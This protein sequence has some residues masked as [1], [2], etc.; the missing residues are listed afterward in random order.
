[1]SSLKSVFQEND[2]PKFVKSIKWP[3]RKCHGTLILY[4]YIFKLMMKI[5]LIGIM[6]ILL[7]RRQHLLAWT[8]TE[9][10]LTFTILIHLCISYCR[11]K[12]FLR[13]TVRDESGHWHLWTYGLG[14]QDEMSKFI[15]NHKLFNEVVKDN[16]C[17]TTSVVSI[18]K[19]V[20][21]VIANEEAYILKDS[22]MKRII[23]NEKVNYEVSI[24]SI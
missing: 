16:F 15:V 21:D 20:K 1:M 14:T 12:D 2:C 7:P 10:S 17:C 3:S 9:I 24:T 19:S 22:N 23:R 5:T 13:M 6:E 8:Q 4:H 18:D 11:G